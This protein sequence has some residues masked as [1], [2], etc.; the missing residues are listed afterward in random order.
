MISSI[1][2][3]TLK[4]YNVALKKWWLYCKEKIVDLYDPDVTEIISFLTWE[5]EKGLSHSSLNC[6]RSAISLI[7]KSDI[8]QNLMMRRFFQGLSKIRPSRPKYD[9]TWDPKIVINYLNTQDSNEKLDLKMISKKLITLLALITAHRMQTFSLIKLENIKIS[10]LSIEIFIPDP[11]KTSRKNS[12]QPML[13]LPVF[14]QNKKLCVANTLQ[15]YIK[16]TEEKR[17]SIKNLFI[18]INK[19]IKAVTSQ[20]LSNWVKEI[21]N[22]SGIEKIFTAHSIRHA[23]TSSAKRS[24]VD[25][26]VIRK[27]AGWTEK[28]R[29]FA[30][31]YDREIMPDNRKFALSILQK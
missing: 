23:S 9:Y 26:E 7:V 25:L 24:G 17:G 15:H 13:V 28:S 6:I 14:K 12:M 29:T 11:I 3:S 19:P 22:E 31:F 27:T 5:F 16:L 21:L 8:A 4:N 10:P 18:S 20:T 30:R 2:D 1:T